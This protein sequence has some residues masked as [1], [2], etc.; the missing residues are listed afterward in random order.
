MKNK[1]KNGANICYNDQINKYEHI[2]SPNV[3]IKSWGL[4]EA[5]L[6]RPG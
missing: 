6:I 4:S 3:G 2:P 1:K 5:E